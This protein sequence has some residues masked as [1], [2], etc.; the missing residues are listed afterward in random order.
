MEHLA[1][2]TPHETL[3]IPVAK[4]ASSEGIHR[5]VDLPLCQDG[6]VRGAGEMK[7]VKN[8]MVKLEAVWL[9]GDHRLY[10][11]VLRKTMPSPS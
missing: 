1:M 8:L 4:K 6:G 11:L 2:G 3:R 10:R 5:C 7:G 9:S